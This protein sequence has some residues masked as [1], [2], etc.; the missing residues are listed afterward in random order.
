[1]FATPG[2]KFLAGVLAALALLAAP[3]A[4]TPA[5]KIV[6]YGAHSGATLTLSTKGGKIVVKGNMANHK[7]RGCRFTRGNRVAVCTRR[8][9]SIEL[10]M[11]PSGDL[12]R[13][14]E[15]LPVPLTI[16]LGAGSDKFIGHGERDTCF[17]GGARRNRCIG[18]G[19]NDTCITGP[20]NSDCVGGPG[21]DYCRHG[22]G[23][24]GCWGGPGN[25]VCVM[26]PGQDGCHG[27][28]GNDR[29]YGGAQPDQLYGGRGRDFCDGGPGWGKS[30]TCDAGP[31]R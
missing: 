15:R 16:Y 9:S 11:G 17:P 8:A 24:D 2:R 13:V 6:I 4:A 28:G 7:P 10:Q 19:G 1:M 25:D 23:S 20:R 27:E 12:V 18:G 30:H 26:G 29:L 21:D 5:S 22:T 31:R 14:K 3:T